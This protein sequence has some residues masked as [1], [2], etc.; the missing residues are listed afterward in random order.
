MVVPRASVVLDMKAE[1]RVGASCCWS[2]ET[3]FCVTRPLVAPA[4]SLD[5]ADWM[6]LVAVTA[7]KATSPPLMMAVAMMGIDTTM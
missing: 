1:V 7:W 2:I 5:A 4:A 3:A 6:A